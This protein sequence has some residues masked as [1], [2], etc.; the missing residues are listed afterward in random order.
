MSYLQEVKKRAE[1]ATPGPWEIEPRDSR[2]Y[3]NGHGK[4]PVVTQELIDAIEDSY[5]DLAL[6]ADIRGLDTPLRATF[7]VK[8]ANFIAHARTDIPELLRRLR[9]CE[10]VHQK[11]SSRSLQSEHVPW[12]TN[13]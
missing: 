12:L 6:G 4:P 5:N 3:I 2:Y 8:D 13:S 1:A 7:F 9:S 11:G 10:E